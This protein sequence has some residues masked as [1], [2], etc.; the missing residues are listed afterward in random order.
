MPGNLR[1]QG[2]NPGRHLQ[3]TFDLGLPKKIYIFKRDCLYL[4]PLFMP[5]LPDQS[6]PNFA[7]TS[8]PTQGRL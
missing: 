5:E 1:I 6:P 8:L 2:S 7:Q 3:A 4:C